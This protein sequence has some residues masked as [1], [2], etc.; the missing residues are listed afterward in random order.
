MTEPIN[1][2]SKQNVN[3]VNTSTLGNNL[4]IDKIKVNTGTAISNNSNNNINNNQANQGSITSSV[5][6]KK[7]KEDYKRAIK[8]KNYSKSIDTNIPKNKIVHLPVNAGIVNFN[9][10]TD[11]VNTNTNRIKINKAKK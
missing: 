1:P 4:I 5:D 7:L 3:F 6:K 9:L 2:N 10:N 8:E 11:V